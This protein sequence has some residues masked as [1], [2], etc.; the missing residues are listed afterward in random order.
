MDRMENDP[1][2]GAAPGELPVS[3][4]GYFVPAAPPHVD[5]G[6]LSLRDL[7][8][9]T[10]DRKRLVAIVTLAAAALAA[11]AAF[12]MTP[13]YRATAILAPVD[14]GEEKAGILGALGAFASIAS[15]AGIGSGLQTGGKDEAIAILKSRAFTE[16]FV[17]DNNLLPVLFEDEWDASTKSWQSSDPDDVP[18][19]FMAFEMF[20]EDL[21]SID[22]DA[23]TGLVMLSIEWSDPVVAAEWVGEHV[24]RVNALMR[25]RAI[26]DAEKSL[27]FLNKELGSTSAVEIRQAIF[28]V[29]EGQYKSITL[30]STRD[31]FVFRV[32]DPALPPVKPAR[33]KKV[34]MIAGGLLVGGMFGVLAA[35]LLPRRAA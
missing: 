35:L 3:A 6:E 17:R 8:V 22:V 33:P 10:W 32:V 29:I 24:R 1:K 12:A 31:E 18:T 7:W 30:A 28:G 21:R 16:L 14:T 25:A 15:A 9:R 34:L 5:G 23:A 11:I 13:V 19:L 4:F 26:A 2:R 20:D 27:A